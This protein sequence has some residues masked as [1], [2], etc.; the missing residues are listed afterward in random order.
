MVRFTVVAPLP[1]GSVA[2]ENEQVA[3]SGR[4]RHARFRAAA[5]PGVGVKM[6]CCV[7]DPPAVAFTEALLEARVNPGFSTVTA[8][9]AWSAAPWE[10]VTVRM[11][12]LAPTG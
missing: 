5:I 7:A 9:V 8:A 1:A 3:C 2:G 10:S 4:L 12:L 6:S 11:T